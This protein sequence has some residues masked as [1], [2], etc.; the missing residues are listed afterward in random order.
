LVGDINKNQNV[1]YFSELPYHGI[2]GLG[3]FSTPIEKNQSFIDYLYDNN[4]I[5]NNTLQYST[6]PNGQ[7]QIEFGVFGKP[8]LFS[9]TKVRYH[10][11]AI[12]S[13][14][15]VMRIDINDVRFTNF[16][17]PTNSSISSDPSQT[18]MIANWIMGGDPYLT[19]ETNV[20]EEL[21]RY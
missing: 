2:L 20:L 17:F 13:N 18:W 14:L 5:A 16:T 1:S 21:N 10:I 19:Y 9:L 4:T 11:E 7:K 12:T 8:S 3:P 15:N 6:L